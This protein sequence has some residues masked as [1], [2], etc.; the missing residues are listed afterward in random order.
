LL[1]KLAAYFEVVFFVVERLIIFGIVASPIRRK[2]VH[3]VAAVGLHGGR[4][5]SLATTGIHSITEE[6]GERD[7]HVWREHK[8]HGYRGLHMEQ[9]YKYGTWNTLERTRI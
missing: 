8:H 9:Y 5:F 1:P 3:H 2:K 4:L 7:K 6:R